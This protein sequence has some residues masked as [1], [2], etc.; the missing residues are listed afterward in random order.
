MAY[1]KHYVS[2]QPIGATLPTVGWDPRCGGTADRQFAAWLEGTNNVVID[3]S[4]G[5]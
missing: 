5:P 3:P 2:M 4:P 1:T